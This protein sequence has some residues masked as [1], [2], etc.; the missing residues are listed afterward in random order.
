MDLRL[1]G[2]LQNCIR[3]QPEGFSE[4]TYQVEDSVR[5]KDEKG[6]EIEKSCPISNFIRWRYVEEKLDPQTGKPSRATR[7]AVADTI[8]KEK[9]TRQVGLNYKSN[10]KKVRLFWLICFV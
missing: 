4:S 3:V 2:N 7:G 1:P 10:G 9:L 6:I 5:Y 8:E